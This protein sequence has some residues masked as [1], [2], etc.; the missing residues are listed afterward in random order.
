MMIN[1]EKRMEMEKLDEEILELIKKKKKNWE[2][3]EKRLKIDRRILE[4]MIKERKLGEIKVSNAKRKILHD[5]SYTLESID[6]IEHGISILI[7]RGDEVV[8]R[9]IVEV[10]F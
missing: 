8:F 6:E 4:K 5:G 7:C 3:I 9:G 2:Y 1:E 10:V